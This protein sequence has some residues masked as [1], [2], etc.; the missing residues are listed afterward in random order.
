M[1]LL[2]A[3]PSLLEDALAWLAEVLALACVGVALVAVVV[4]LEYLRYAWRR[5][6]WLAEHGRWVETE[7]VV[8]ANEDGVSRLS[9]GAEVPALQEGSQG[10]RYRHAVGEH[11]RLVGYPRFGALSAVAPTTMTVPGTAPAAPDPS[12]ARPRSGPGTSP[13]A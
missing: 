1:V 13:D 6:A 9:T 5:R 4:G 2:P 3:A 12:G 7:G 10:W 11:V 8:V